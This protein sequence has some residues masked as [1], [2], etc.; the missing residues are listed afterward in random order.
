M[1]GLRDMA[2]DASTL[3]IAQTIA[4]LATGIIWSRYSLVITPKNWNLFS[5]N[6]FVALTQFV[7]MCRAIH[8]HYFTDQIDATTVPPFV[9]FTVTGNFTNFTSTPLPI[10]EESFLMSNATSG[11]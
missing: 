2:R 1:A 4:L 7:Q 10:E 3:S 8:Y 11:V 9:N 5:V 6:A